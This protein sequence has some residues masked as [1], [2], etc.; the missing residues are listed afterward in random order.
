MHNRV[1]IVYQNTFAS[2]QEKIKLFKTYRKKNKRSEE[3]LKRK[4]KRK[5]TIASTVMKIILSSNH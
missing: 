4:K 2:I 5:K 3:N 1:D